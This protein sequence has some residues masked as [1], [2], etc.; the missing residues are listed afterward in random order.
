MSIKICTTRQEVNA[1]SGT[2]ADVD[3]NRQMLVR[4]NDDPLKSGVSV[5]YCEN[6]AGAITFP[7]RCWRV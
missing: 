7:A 2:V 4:S 6:D 5:L 3:V 1:I